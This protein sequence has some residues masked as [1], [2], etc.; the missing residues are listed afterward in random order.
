[1]KNHP[2]FGADRRVPFDLSNEWVP[3][4]PTREVEQ[5][6]PYLLGR[7]VDDD[8]RIDRS[9]QISCGSPER[10][11]E[12]E[13]ANP[14]RCFLS[15]TANTFDSWGGS[16]TWKTARGRDMHS[17]SVRCTI[18]EFVEP[19]NQDRQALSIDHMPRVWRRIATETPRRGVIAM[20]IT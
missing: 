16:A 3:V 12:Y 4:R 10:I 14:T 15:Q 11:R 17:V 2:Q 19:E 6:G 18:A 5:Q 13:N 20:A 1:M 9:D 7:N 8:V